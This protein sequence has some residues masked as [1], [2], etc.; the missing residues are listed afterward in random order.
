MVE[1]FCQELVRVQ[2]IDSVEV[3]GIWQ[4]SVEKDDIGRSQSMLNS[5]LHVCQNGFQSG[6]IL[7]YLIQRSPFGHLSLN[8]L[9]RN[10]RNRLEPFIGQQI[11]QGCL[12]RAGGTRYH[13]PVGLDPEWS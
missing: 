12:A 2:S 11:D 3:E 5:H 8:V 9:S 4:G 10:L 1:A 13:M 7:K 6:P